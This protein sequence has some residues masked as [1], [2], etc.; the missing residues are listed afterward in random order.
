[1]ASDIAERDR[2]LKAVNL[3]LLENRKESVESGGEENNVVGIPP[4][5]SLLDQKT[6]FEYVRMGIHTCDVICSSDVPSIGTWKEQF[7]STPKTKKNK[8]TRTVENC[9]SQ[10]H[11]L[12]DRVHR[13]LK[14]GLLVCDDC[15]GYRGDENI[16]FAFP[17]FD[18]EMFRV[19]PLSV[20]KVWR[21]FRG[22]GR[23]TSFSLSGWDGTLG[24]RSISKE[25]MQTLPDVQELYD[26]GR[27]AEAKEI[28]SFAAMEQVQNLMLAQYIKTR[29]Q[30]VQTNRVSGFTWADTLKSQTR[31][32]LTRDKLK[33]KERDCFV[34][35]PSVDVLQDYLRGR[36]DGQFSPQSIAVWTQLN[37]LEAM[38]LIHQERTRCLTQLDSSLSAWF[39]NNGL[40]RNKNLMYFTRLQSAIKEE[41]F[42]LTRLLERLPVHEKLIEHYMAFI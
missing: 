36:L 34:F 32:G 3:A 10:Y 28:C 16:A 30:D 7:G 9:F 21:L 26:F 39:E 18:N 20:L 38:R 4:G 22:S 8:D 5:K 23:Y 41:H 6:F 31:S 42:A 27:G 37:W 19:G 13:L 35:N 40:Q 11:E 29:R 2:W 15:D 14:H 24:A 1:L 12:C 33:F 25:L 17:G